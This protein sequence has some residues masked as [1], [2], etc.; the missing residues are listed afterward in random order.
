M[1]LP[2]QPF[3]LIDSALFSFLFVRVYNS[4]ITYLCTLT[5]LIAV[6]VLSASSSEWPIKMVRMLQNTFSLV[7]TLHVLYSSLVSFFKKCLHKLK[8]DNFALHVLSVAM[9]ARE[10]G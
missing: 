6:F 1:I 5:C 10:A 2:N 4:I 9:C 3:F 7:L 8:M